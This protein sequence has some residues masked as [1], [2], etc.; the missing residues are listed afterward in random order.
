MWHIQLIIHPQTVSIIQQA[1]KQARGYYTGIFGI[2]DGENLNSAVAIR[3]IEQKNDKFYF[4]SGG[5][6][7]IQ[8]QLEDEYQELIAK[9]YLPIQKE[10]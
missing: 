6:I 7:T 5:G 3:F 8:S 2:F 9:V 10:K 4:R 1:E